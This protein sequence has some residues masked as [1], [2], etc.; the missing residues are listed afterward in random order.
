M[1]LD[2]SLRFILAN[3]FSEELIYFTSWVDGTFNSQSK[4][5][6]PPRLPSPPTVFLS[7]GMATKMFE[8]VVILSVRVPRCAPWDT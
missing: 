6:P 7:M 1:W 8:T 3:A 2:G 4:I 5:P